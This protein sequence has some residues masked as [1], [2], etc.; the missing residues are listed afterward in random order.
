MVAEWQMISP[1]RWVF[2]IKVRGLIR[3]TLAF[4]DIGNHGFAFFWQVGGT[5]GEEDRPHGSALSLVAAVAQ[6]ERH[7]GIINLED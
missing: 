1:T 3:E 7:L 5:T 6:A 2:G 4:I